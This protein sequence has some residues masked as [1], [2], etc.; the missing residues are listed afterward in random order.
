MQQ[1]EVFQYATT[2]DL[3]MVYYNISLSS[4][5]QDMTMVV[6]EFGK[7]GYNRLPMGI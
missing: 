3:N 1:L 5:S 2:L 6:T 7:L 4:D